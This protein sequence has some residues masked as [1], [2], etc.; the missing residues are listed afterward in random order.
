MHGVLKR[1]AQGIEYE[2]DPRHVQIILKQ[3]N[4]KGCKAVMTPGTKDEG[5]AKE[6]DKAQRPVE[7]AMDEHKHGIYHAIVT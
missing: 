3:L 6:G 2:A 1:I 4:I 7:E 5:H